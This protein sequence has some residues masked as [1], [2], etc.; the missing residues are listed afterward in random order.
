MSSA[1]T[2]TTQDGTCS[3]QQDETSLLQVNGA[4][5][6][7]MKRSSDQ[8]KYVQ[9]DEEVD[10]DTTNAGK[11]KEFPDDKIWNM[12]SAEDLLSGKVKLEE[13]E[14]K[15]DKV[16]DTMF[17]CRQ[18]VNH[19]HCGFFSHIDKLVG[20][21]PHCC[22]CRFGLAACK[23]PLKDGWWEKQH[24]KNYWYGPSEGQKK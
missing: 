10:D 20:Q 2:C 15:V 8:Q 16:K 12:P 3:D 5:Q 4:L 23:N 22:E 11:E 14:V 9:D 18:C 24:L 21:C 7:S 13:G 17:D 6:P 1:T 19:N